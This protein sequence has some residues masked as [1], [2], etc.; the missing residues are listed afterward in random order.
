MFVQQLH[1]INFEI[2]STSNKGNYTLWWDIFIQRRQGCARLCVFNVVIWNLPRQLHIN[3]HYICCSYK[4][5]YLMRFEHYRTALWW[6]L[7]WHK[8]CLLNHWGKKI[9]SDPLISLR[10]EY[11]FFF[12]FF[13]HH[14]HH[15]CTV[16]WV[17]CYYYCYLC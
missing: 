11:M 12:K 6:N 7:M 2:Q 15:E 4:K 16:H 3:N 5:W 1:T 13:F 17:L 14:V 9:I 10:F 8:L